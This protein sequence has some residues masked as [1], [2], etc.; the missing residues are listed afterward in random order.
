MAATQRTEIA[1]KAAQ[2]RWGSKR[3]SA[4]RFFCP[5][6]WSEK[7]TWSLPLI[8]TQ[9]LRD[10]WDVDRRLSELRLTRQKLLDARAVAL[11]EA[12]NATPY[13]CANAAGTFSYQHGTWALR[14]EFVSDEWRVDR[15][16]GVEAIWNDEIKIRVIF[17]NVD[18]ACN[19]DQMPKPR[20]RKGAG[21][22][23]ACMGNLFGDLPRYAP[24]PAGNEATYY[25]MVDDRGAA[26]LTRPVVTGGTFSAYI[27]RIY[28]LDGGD[29]AGRLPLD[30]DDALSDF[31]PQVARKNA[32]G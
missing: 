19:N 17:S 13:H 21:A 24:R 23:R 20:S 3:T 14:N 4:C 29:P 25:L 16:D 6:S 27:E 15:A 10:P 32:S 12:A 31:D 26:E 30:D 22:E 1:R 11:Q 28:L 2:T 5:T 8:E 18:I 9:V 7:S